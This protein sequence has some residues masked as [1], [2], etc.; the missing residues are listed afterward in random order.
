V[1]A[2]TKFFNPQ[3]LNY[4]VRTLKGVP[5]S[6]IYRIVRTGQVRINKGRAKVSYKL[7]ENDLL[8]IPPLRMSEPKTLTVSERLSHRLHAS[9]IFEDDAIIIVNKPSGIA[10]HGGS[11]LSLGVIEAF[12]QL[13]PEL[14]DLSL[15]HRLDKETSGCLILAKK[16][17][18]LRALTGLLAE[19]KVKKIYWAIC[20]HHWSMKHNVR[21]DQPLLKNILQ[22]G[23][24]MVKI[25]GEGKASITDF[26][27]LENFE[28]Y[29]FVQA[30]PH[31]GRTHQIRVHCAYLGHPI[32]GDVKYGGKPSQRVYLHARSVAFH[33]NG[34][35]YQVEAKVD[36]EWEHVCHIKNIN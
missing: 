1:F 30:N 16:R 18:A 28:D 35:P 12:R 19:R 13:R 33:L 8:R 25:D 26:T 22:S 24:R 14:K 29:C 21:V 7:F 4:L 11:G 9:V 6:Y 2:A 36:T 23:E 27:C 15:V 20:D 3:P 32:L 17:S 5:K 31:T 34:K 10:V